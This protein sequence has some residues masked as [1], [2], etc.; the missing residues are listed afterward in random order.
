[1]DNG[2]RI[3][4]CGVGCGESW[5]SEEAIDL[6]RQ[7]VKNRF[8]ERIR[9][10]YHDLS[11]FGVASLSLKL[12]KKIEDETLSL[13][14]LVI[15]GEAKISGQFDIRLLLDAIEAEIEIGW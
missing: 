14:L 8:G 4:E 10:E 13:P 5:D 12:Q 7:R 2:A 3:N 1:M 15:N 9:L 6:A 11:K